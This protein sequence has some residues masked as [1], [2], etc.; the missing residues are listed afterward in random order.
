MLTTS[1]PNILLPQ[2]VKKELVD[3]SSQ[4]SEVSDHSRSDLQMKDELMDLDPSSDKSLLDQKEELKKL[5]RRAYQQKRRQ[6]Q[7][8][9]KE[10]TVQPKKRPRKGSKVEE[11]Y[12]TYIDGVLHQLRTLPPMTVAE[13][14]LNKN[15]TVVPVFGCGELSKLGGKDYDSR[16][17]DL[18]GTYGNAVL[19]GYSDFYNTKPYGEAESLPEKTAASTQ[20]GFYDQEFPLIKFNVDE[21]KKYDLFC[22]EDSPDSIISSSSPECHTFEPILKFPGLRLISE[23]EDEEPEEDAITKMRLSPVVPLIQPIPIRLKAAG[24]YLKDYAEMVGGVLENVLPSLYYDCVSQENKE[25]IQ[26]SDNL[27]V[28]SSKVGPPSN[29]PTKDSGNVTVTLTLTS[30][31]AEDIMG[32]LRDLANILHIPAPTSYQIVERTSTPPSQKLGL[33]RTKGKD[34]REGTPI[35]IQS[36]L[37]G[38]AKFCRHCDVVILNNMIRKKVSDLPCLNKNTDLLDEDEDLF[39]CSSTCFMQFALMHRSPSITEDKVSAHR[40]KNRATGKRPLVAT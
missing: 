15:F 29:S 11:D 17:G 28:K 3:E 26:T 40:N 36:I 20:R 31:A 16:F 13:P 21:D 19:P 25:N 12:D 22:R 2:D 9:G 32:V 14:V 33:Y 18:N 4:H 8:M 37:N 10:A 5:K 34:G 6:N 35:D 30:S 38:A 27:S 1:Q 24:P 7:I 39:F 23:D